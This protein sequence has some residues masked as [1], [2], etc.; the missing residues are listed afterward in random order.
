MDM[1]APIGSRFKQPVE[2][3]VIILLG[4]KAWLSVDSS[5]HYMLRDIG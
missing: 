5:L 3:T 2:V 1:T 4:E